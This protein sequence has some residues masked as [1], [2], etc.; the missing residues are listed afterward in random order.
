MSILLITI[1]SGLGT[2]VPRREK[3]CLQGFLQV[4]FKPACSASDLLEFAGS[5]S[6]YDIF[7]NANNKGADQTAQAGLRLCCS[8][9]PENR[10]S[11]NEAQMVLEWSSTKKV[12]SPVVHH[13]A[14][15]KILFVLY[16][17]TF[18]CTVYRPT[19]IKALQ[20]ATYPA[21]G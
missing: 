13:R 1:F 16:L 19:Q 10:F 6:R 2:N 9:T 17:P 11:R 18:V 12:H 14:E 4:R 5:K 21:T 8:Q 20:Q 7:Q 15:N 3:I